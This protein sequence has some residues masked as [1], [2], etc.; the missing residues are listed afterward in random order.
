MVNE[1]IPEA[2]KYLE[3]SARDF[4]KYQ[5]QDH[6]VYFEAAWRNY[7]TLRGIEKLDREPE[8]PSNYSWEAREKFYKKISFSGWGGSS[9]HDSVSLK[10][11]STSLIIY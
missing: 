9:G 1:V 3:E 2:K 4:E 7:I 5:E 10:L 8:F 6:L 11:C